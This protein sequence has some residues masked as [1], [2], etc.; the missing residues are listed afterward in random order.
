[1]TGGPSCVGDY[2]RRAA[3]CDGDATDPRPCTW[4][5]KCH[6]WQQE[7]SIL[8]L[9]PY[10]EAER[11]RAE[12]GPRVFEARCRELADK[13]GPP[14]PL[15]AHRRGGKRRAPPRAR[16]VPDDGPTRRLELLA[17]HIVDRLRAELGPVV[18][19]VDE[20]VLVG[21]L[22]AV[23]MLAHRGRLDVSVRTGASSSVPVL[24]LS[25]CPGLQGVEAAVRLEGAEAAELAAATGA[26]RLRTLTTGGLPSALVL[27]R[28]C[29][30][31]PLVAA[32]A[33]AVTAI[34]GQG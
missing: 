12:D 32:V 11:L 15:P 21:Q 8:G 22:V 9:D 5:A 10:T 4:R 3:P 34:H 20:A 23:D 31:E 26:A 16:R 24:S 33:A 19:P 27:R 28:A 14:P 25:L 6:G 2:A 1:M 7:C 17:W 18:F 29:A 30:L 13:W